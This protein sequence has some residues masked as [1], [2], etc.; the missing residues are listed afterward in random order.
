MKHLTEYILESQDQTKRYAD[1]YI[2]CDDKVLVLRRANY[3]KKFRSLWGVIGGSIEE[4][5][6][7]SKAAAIREIL[8]ET[9]IELTFNEQ[10]KMRLLRTIHNDDGST[11]D[12]WVVEMESK[13]DVKISREHSKYEWFDD[14]TEGI[15]KWMPNVF[16]T[17]QKILR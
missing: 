2:V 14:K 10:H 16:Q 13:P 12:Q 7:D 3:M 6:K 5:D 8:E 11:T 9:G 1:A 15:Y 17:I 4:S